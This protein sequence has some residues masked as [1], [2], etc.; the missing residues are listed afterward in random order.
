MRVSIDKAGRV[1]IPK[2]VRE[3]LG[4]RAGQELDLDSYDG[5]IRLTV[6]ARPMHIEGRGKRARIVTEGAMPTL[7][8]DVVRA[9]L[10]AGRDR[11]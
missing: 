4:L 3:Q 10:E 1:V 7:T 8:A 2:G 5:S 9:A 6:P 11:R